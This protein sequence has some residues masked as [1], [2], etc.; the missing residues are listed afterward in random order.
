MSLVRSPAQTRSQIAAATSLSSAWTGLGGWFPST[1]ATRSLS[2]RKNR[3]PPPLS[4]SSTAEC[5]GV[6]VT[7]PGS[8]SSSGAPS[9]GAST[10]QPSPPGSPPAPDQTISPAEVSSSIRAGE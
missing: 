4:T 9:A 7:S 3:A 5:T 10:S 8:G 6:M 1:A 2:M